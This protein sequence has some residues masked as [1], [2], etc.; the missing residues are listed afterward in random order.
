MARS[1]SGAVGIFDGQGELGRMW[2]VST[3]KGSEAEGLFKIGVCDRDGGQKKLVS[4]REIVCT[5]RSNS[6]NH[7]L[8]GSFLRRRRCFFTSSRYPDDSIT[9]SPW[10]ESKST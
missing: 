2:N 7:Y 6:L 3:A 4:S 9:C 10:K 1:M 8:A 5:D